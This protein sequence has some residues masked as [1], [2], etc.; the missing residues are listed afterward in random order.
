MSITKKV[1]KW[2]GTNG[3]SLHKLKLKSNSHFGVK[4]ILAPK[5]E[6]SKVSLRGCAHV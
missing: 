5:E 4:E 2:H 3:T 6:V 1:F